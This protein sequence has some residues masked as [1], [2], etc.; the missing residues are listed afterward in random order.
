MIE[1]YWLSKDGDYNLAEHFK[2]KEFK[3]KDGSE[4]IVVDSR[5][6]EVLEMIREH[7]N[8]PVIINSAYRTPERNSRVGGAK[9]SYHMMG[10]AADIQVR[11]VSSKDVA[12][13]ASSLMSMG[14]VI[15]YT[16]FVHIDV[17]Q[18]ERYRKGVE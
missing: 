2:V 16:N 7:Y 18:L 9:Y 11:G 14:G 10:K 6:V 15:C 3:C 13:V 17:R 5:L 8:K 12:K 1:Q 4:L